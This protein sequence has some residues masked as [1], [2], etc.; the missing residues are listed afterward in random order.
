M[1]GTEGED[2]GIPRKTPNSAQPLLPSL[3]LPE[4]RTG[5]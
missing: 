3:K 5:F 2:Q 4:D 1:M